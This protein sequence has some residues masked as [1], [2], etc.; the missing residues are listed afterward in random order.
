LIDLND[1]RKNI[2]Y[3]YGVKEC[4]HYSEDGVI[5][6]IFTEIGLEE[7]SFIVEFGEKIPQYLRESMQKD[8]FGHL[9]DSKHPD[10]QNKFIKDVVNII[11][12]FGER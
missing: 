8:D 7:K 6:K 10:C 5:E 11:Y 2:Y 1:Y 4:P 12:E 9:I 3:N